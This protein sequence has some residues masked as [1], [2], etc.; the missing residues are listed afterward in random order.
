MRDGREEK[1][2]GG[3]GELKYLAGGVVRARV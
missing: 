3:T 2:W 1:K